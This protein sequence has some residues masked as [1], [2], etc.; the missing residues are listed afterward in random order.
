M[1][2]NGVILEEAAG[3]GLSLIKQ[4]VTMRRLRLKALSMMVPCIEY[5]LRTGKCQKVGFTRS[6]RLNPYGYF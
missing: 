1:Y 6:M 3:G 2:I 5:G 4:N